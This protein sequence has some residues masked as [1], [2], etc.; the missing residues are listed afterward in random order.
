M[1]GFFLK[2]I[3]LEVFN[4]WWFYGS[5]KFFFTTNSLT[6]RRNTISFFVSKISFINLMTAVGSTNDQNTMRGVII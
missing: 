1:C 5:E 2:E 3:C 4:F 6:I